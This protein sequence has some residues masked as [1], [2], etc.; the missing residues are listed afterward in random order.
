VPDSGGAGRWRGGLTTDRIYRVE[1]D[2]AT[3]TVTAERGR[4]APKG[5][6]GGLE[7][8]RF[9]STVT[10]PDGSQAEMPSKGSAVIVRKG[11]RVSI[12]CAG[13]GGYGDPLDR[14]PERVLKD[15]VD[16]YVT[17]QA[18]RELY[19]VALSD[20]NR[21]IDAP[22]TLALRRRLRAAKGK[23]EKKDKAGKGVSVAAE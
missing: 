23:A 16:G 22:S 10:R 7:G 13:S 5:L 17:A 20:D 15:V 6:F 18:A 11:D 12:R 4:V 19:G 21:R 1:Y 14:E 9:R 8:A 2:E 3:L